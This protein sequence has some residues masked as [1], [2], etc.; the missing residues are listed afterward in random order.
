MTKNHK[1]RLK[2]RY[3]KHMDNSVT[4]VDLTKKQPLTHYPYL[5]E[6]DRQLYHIQQ[7][8]LK[9]IMFDKLNSAFSVTGTFNGAYIICQSEGE[10]RRIFHNYYKG[11]SIL[12]ITL[13]KQFNLRDRPF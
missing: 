13:S 8:E 2:R 1:K 12:N 5:E 4:K 9:S 10:A 3:K 7:K 6:Q 11:E